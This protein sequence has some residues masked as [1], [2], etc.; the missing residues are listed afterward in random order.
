MS[1]SGSV[2]SLAGSTPRAPGMVAPKPAAPSIDPTR[3]QGFDGPRQPP[4]ATAPAPGTL[5]GAPPRPAPPPPVGAVVGP[6]D[7]GTPAATGT[8]DVDAMIREFLAGQ[9]RNAGKANTAEEE[10]LIRQQMADAAGGMSVNARARAGRSGMASSGALVGQEGDIRRAASQDALDQILG[11]RRTEDQRGIENAMGA[12][13]AET[14]MR[15]AAADDELRRMALAALQAEMGLDAGEVGGGGAADGLLGIVGAET[16]APAL[17]NAGGATAPSINNGMDA[18][19]AIPVA[20]PPPGATQTAT[21]GLW[22]HSD[23]RKYYVVN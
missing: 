11:L 13:G 21:P 22:Y 20:S 5:P 18:A 15:R 19:N 17:A 1:F 10:A 16:E 23:T 4:S 6:E 8:D 3:V 7:K 9:L 2:P 12:I 14:G